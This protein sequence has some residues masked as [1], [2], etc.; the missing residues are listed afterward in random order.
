[1]TENARDW[2]MSPEPGSLAALSVNKGIRNAVVSFP[3]TTL[4]PVKMGRIHG[5][6]VIT[7]TV[8][9]VIRFILSI[10]GGVIIISAQQCLG[11]S[12]AKLPK[13]PE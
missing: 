7:N 6:H 3:K 9:N 8:G 1:M 5:V 12:K 10:A 2:D 4:W 13:S 11:M